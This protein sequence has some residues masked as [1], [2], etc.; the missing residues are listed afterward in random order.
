MGTA[1]VRDSASVT[2]TEAVD[3]TRRGR[4][5]DRRQRASKV[6]SVKVHPLVWKQA[7]KL[8]GGNRKRIQIVDA[9][10]VIVLN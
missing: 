8:C 6:E 7:V 9:Q 2:V 3:G 1:A 5:A 10:T 4:G